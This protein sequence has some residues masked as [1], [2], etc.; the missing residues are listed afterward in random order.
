[1]A[2]YRC[3][4]SSTLY[5]VDI[6]VEDYWIFLLKWANFT[7]RPTFIQALL[8]TFLCLKCFKKTLCVGGYGAMRN[9]V[10]RFSKQFKRI[11]LQRI[12]IK[13]VDRPRI[14]CEGLPLSLCV[15]WTQSLPHI[16]TFWK[17]VW[18]WEA[19]ECCHCLPPT[20]KTRGEVTV[21]KYV[22]S[23]SCKSMATCHI[24]LFSLC[25]RSF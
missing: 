13:S 9:N 21:F 24:R 6:H 7:E 11:R 14:I 2:G 19:A 15:V 3:N 12:S 17:I 10:S 8:S 23:M 5:T 22:Y 4:V 18:R 25:K 20:G 1:M 16:I